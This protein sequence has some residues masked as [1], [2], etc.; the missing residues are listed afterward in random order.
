MEYK[1]KINE[2]L[3]EVYDVSFDISKLNEILVKLRG[4]KYTYYGNVISEPSDKALKFSLF[5][6]RD[7]KVKEY[8]LH[9]KRSDIDIHPIPETFKK[10]DVGYSISYYYLKYPKLYY[11]ITDIINNISQKN[12]DE[13]LKYD[14][15]NEIDYLNKD[16][17]EYD[18]LVN[19]EKK[20]NLNFDFEGL[21]NLYLEALSNISFKLVSKINISNISNGTVE[22]GLNF[23]K[24]RK[25]VKEER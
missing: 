21:Y 19:L 4:Y 10:L 20:A 16:N 6:T 2:N 17:P 8:L 24:V 23:V 13:L 7:E 25:K 3:M 5:K 14:C 18:E 22:N 1:K 9:I 12:I 11:I 15:F